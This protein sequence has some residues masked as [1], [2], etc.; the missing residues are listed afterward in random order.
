MKA[1]I[2]FLAFQFILLTQHKA[3]MTFFSKKKKKYFHLCPRVQFQYDARWQCCSLFLLMEAYSS[4]VFDSVFVFFVLKCFLNRKKHMELESE[5]QS[6]QKANQHLENI[7]EATKAHKRREVSQLHK[8]H[9][10]TLK[11]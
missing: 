9:R 10:E 11:V 2:N 5:L 3:I 8:L 1:Q 4:R 6:L 7:L